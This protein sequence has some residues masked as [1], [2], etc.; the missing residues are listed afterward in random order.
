MVNDLNVLHNGLP[1]K[2][3]HSIFKK[4]SGNE[5]VQKSLYFE[6]FQPQKNKDGKYIKLKKNIK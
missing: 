6:E 4:I 3:K 5:S 2:D 1:L